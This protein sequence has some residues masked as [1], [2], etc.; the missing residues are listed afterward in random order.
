MEDWD[1]DS[2][3]VIG[4]ALLD[5]PGGLKGAGIASVAGAASFRFE[6]LPDLIADRPGVLW[7]TSATPNEFVDGLGLRFPQLRT[8]AW[9]GTPVPH[10][11]E[12]LGVDPANHDI[13]ARYVAEVAARCVRRAK[14]YFPEI[15]TNGDPAGTFADCIRP[16]VQPNSHRGRLDPPIADAL[17]ASFTRPGP[18]PGAEPA[19]HDV[20]V[21]L[22][23]QRI[24][25]L[26]RVL[27][28]Q[29]PD[30]SWRAVDPAGINELYMW[31]A[32]SDLP[33]IASV[34]LSKP[35]AKLVPVIPRRGVRMWLAQPELRAL[36]KMVVGQ[37]T[38]IFVAERYMS[39]ASSLRFPPPV[40]LPVDHASM[41]TGL[42]AECMLQALTTATGQIGAVTET[43]ASRYSPRSAWLLSTARTVVMSEAAKLIARQFNVVGWGLSHVSVAIP[44][45]RIPALRKYVM[46]ASGLVFPTFFARREVARTFEV[47]G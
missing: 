47:A 22:P 20:L 14:G 15:T 18:P 44:L 4:V 27:A 12:E 10:I 6:S 11:A 29:V 31:C 13:C 33:V 37:I 26:E 36:T 19:A 35:N 2:D 21:R 1:E 34:L 7:I 28:S 32:D 39:C 38:A 16:S 25:H 42:F 17:R 23:I 3:P 45:A 41:A 40:F 43:Q 46:E 5:E 8:N 24:L 9:L 30:G